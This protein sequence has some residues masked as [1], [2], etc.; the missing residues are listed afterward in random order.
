MKICSVK[1][2]HWNSLISYILSFRENVVNISFNSM[3]STLHKVRRAAMPKTPSKVSDLNR[4]FEIPYV[5]HNYGMTKRES[6]DGEPPIVPPTQFFDHAYE[7]D[8]YA[9]CIFSSKDVIKSV[10]AKTEENER[11]LYADGTFKICPMGVFKLVLII[12]AELL[13][14]VSCFEF[15][16][17]MFFPLIFAKIC[18]TLD[19]E[20]IHK[21]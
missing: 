13:G 21:I 19:L 5:R 9:Y 12:F 8:D 18:K 3:E 14:H 1:R 11:V 20:T 2:F 10:L 4:L 15:P 17:L 16:D 6:K 7:C